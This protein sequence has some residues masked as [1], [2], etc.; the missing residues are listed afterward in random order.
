LQFETRLFLLSTQLALARTPC[1]KCDGLSCCA[2]TRRSVS[3]LN[4]NGPT[5]PPSQFPAHACAAISPSPAVATSP[6]VPFVGNPTGDLSHVAI[7]SCAGSPVR[8]S[9]SYRVAESREADWADSAVVGLPARLR[10]A[11]AQRDQM[12]C[13][14]SQRT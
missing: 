2:S 6:M 11:Q 12:H 1:L 13:P 14:E 8:E 5:R 7:R 4:I 9:N 10:R 3:R